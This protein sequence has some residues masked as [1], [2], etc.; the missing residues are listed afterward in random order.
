VKFHLVPVSTIDAS[1]D[2]FAEAMRQRRAEDLPVFESHEDLSKWVIVSYDSET[3]PERVLQ[4]IRKVF[5][6]RLG[7]NAMTLPNTITIVKFEPVEE[8]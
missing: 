7:L 5:Y 1:S 2:D 8:P 4:Q 3:T 6:E